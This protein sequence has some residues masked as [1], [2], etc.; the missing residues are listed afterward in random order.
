M[1]FYESIFILR[2]SLADA[3]AVAIQEK[4]KGAL[5]KLGASIIKA[6]NWGKKK[7]AYEVGHDRRGTYSL[8]Q[9]E[10]SGN[11]VGELER[12]YRLEDSVMKFLTVRVEEEDLQPKEE[13]AAKTVESDSGGV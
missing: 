9:F 13:E 3:E 2:S 1:A 5:E 6:D 8:F 7:L 12:L 10:A 4:L 11:V